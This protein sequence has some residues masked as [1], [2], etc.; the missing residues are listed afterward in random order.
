M[1]ERRFDDERRRLQAEMDA[2]IEKVRTAYRARFEAIDRAEELMKF[3]ATGDPAK[4]EETE[5]T[6]VPPSSAAEVEEPSARLRREVGRLVA[7]WHGELRIGDV[8]ERLP[9]AP[10]QAIRA[11]LDR[12]AKAGEVR[13]VRAGGPQQEPIY[14]PC[15]PQYGDVEPAER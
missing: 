9:D 8:R 10:A 3:A 5:P 14:E 15:E 1:S 2:E 6:E 7:G 13:I 11:C 4:L 12:M